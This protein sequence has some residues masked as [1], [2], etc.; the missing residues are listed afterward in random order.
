MWVELYITATLWLIVRQ[1]YKHPSFKTGVIKIER[2]ALGLNLATNFLKSNISQ[3]DS[4]TCCT[5]LYVLEQILTFK[6]RRRSD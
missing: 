1:K 4:T 3:D 2:I 5:E 6:L